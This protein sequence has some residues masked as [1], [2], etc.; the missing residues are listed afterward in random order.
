MSAQRTVQKM[1]K[2]EHL[3]YY[4][5]CGPCC[6]LDPWETI[7]LLSIYTMIQSLD[8][9][10]CHTATWQT[11]YVITKY[12]KNLLNYKVSISESWMQIWHRSLA[13]PHPLR[14]S[15]RRSWEWCLSQPTILQWL[16]TKTSPALLGQPWHFRI[17]KSMFTMVLL[18]YIFQYNYQT[19]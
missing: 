18:F 9:V 19:Q 10:I 6:V 5:T 11:I 16:L 15:L 1:V 12:F 14:W 4:G 3:S 17:N 13:L 2:H 8:L 7:G